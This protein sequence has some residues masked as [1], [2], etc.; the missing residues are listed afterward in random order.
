MMLFMLKF[1]KRENIL[2]QY[3]QVGI[4]KTTGKHKELYQVMHQEI[5]NISPTC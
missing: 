4:V 5:G 1:K 3:M 2:L